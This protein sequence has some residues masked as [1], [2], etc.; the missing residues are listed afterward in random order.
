MGVVSGEAVADI[1]LKDIMDMKAGVTIKPVVNYKQITQAGIFCP[2]TKKFLVAGVDTHV[3]V[4]L[5]LQAEVMVRDGQYTVYVGTPMDE[6]SRKEKPV[7]ELRVKPYSAAYD[8]SAPTLL[9]I[10]K[11]YDAK[12]IRSG[13]QE[14]QRKEYPLGRP[15][16]LDLRLKVETE[17]P[18]FDIAEVIQSLYQHRPLTLLTLP[19]PL[20]TVKDHSVSVIFNP[21]DSNTKDAS[22][23]F[24][25]GYAE[26]RQ[27]GSDPEVTTYNNVRVP[28]EIERKCREESERYSGEEKEEKRDECEREN[29]AQ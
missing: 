20:K 16:G 13:H 22:L 23:S 19:L 14:L 5:P 28:S 25:F 24:S 3:H 6:E 27:S 4:A 8:L 10:P 7:F 9:S 11:C 1:Q 2:I 15:L 18:T 12:I 21:R 17:Q 29:I 26:K